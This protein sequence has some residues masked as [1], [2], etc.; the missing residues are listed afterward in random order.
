M[1]K[2]ILFLKS[3]V[4][5]GKPVRSELL[6]QAKAIDAQI[7]KNRVET[8]YSLCAPTS[9]FLT[10]YSKKEIE[11]YFADCRV[12]KIEKMKRDGTP[13]TVV[14]FQKDSAITATSLFDSSKLVNKHYWAVTLMNSGA[15]QNS[16]GS[17]PNPATWFGHAAIVIEGINPNNNEYEMKFSDLVFLGKEV[18]RYF[19]VKEPL[20]TVNKGG[21]RQTQTWVRHKREIGTMLRNIEKEIQEQ[22]EDKKPVFFHRFGSDSIF[23]SPISTADTP[24]SFP[25][26]CMTWAIKKLALAGIISSEAESPLSKV[27]ATP[28]AYNLKQTMIHATNNIIDYVRQS[29]RFSFLCNRLQDAYR[30]STFYKEEPVKT[31]EPNLLSSS[32]TRM[33]DIVAHNLMYH[34]EGEFYEAVA[35]MQ[36]FSDKTITFEEIVEHIHKRRYPSVVSVTNSS[37][38]REIYDEWKKENG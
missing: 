26:N 19:I 28:I 34:I 14:F 12:K 17:I 30:M 33:R 5:L 38:L 36:A 13:S 16:L 1:V 29:P 9:L 25:D 18:V 35:E 20:K 2:N 6:S 22:S 15:S 7:E 32:V 3:R 23:V 37:L 21:E 4:P 27:I 31:P 11:D 10:Q 24:T 8:L